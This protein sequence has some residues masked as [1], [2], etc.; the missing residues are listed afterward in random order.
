MWTRAIYDRARHV[1]VYSIGVAINP[2]VAGDQLTGM[3]R[4]AGLG[5]QQLAQGIAYSIKAEGRNS[6]G[7]AFVREPVVQVF[8]AS[9]RPF[10]IS[11][12]RSPTNM[13][14]TTRGR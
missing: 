13:P 5:S 6:D 12:W 9:P 7:A 2:N 10:Q 14:S 1:T 4:Q 8:L 11:A 3:L